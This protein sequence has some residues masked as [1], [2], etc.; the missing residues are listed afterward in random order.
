MTKEQLKVSGVNFLEKL[1]QIENKRIIAAGN[2]NSLNRCLL[3]SLKKKKTPS[4]DMMRLIRRPCHQ[5]ISV[6]L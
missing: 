6:N 3:R 4:E 5:L 1:N 2:A